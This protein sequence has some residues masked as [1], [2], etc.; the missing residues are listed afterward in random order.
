[1]RVLGRSAWPGHCL[2]PPPP[3]HPR[4]GGSRG[5]GR[6]L[7]MKDI[8]WLLAVAVGNWP[9]VRDGPLGSH[10]QFPEGLL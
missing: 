2:V 4:V 5:G 9:R 10:M 3:P 1:M 8:L 6:P 7:P